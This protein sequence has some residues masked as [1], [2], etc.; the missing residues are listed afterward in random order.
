MRSST[1][2]WVSRSW[3]SCWYAA[4]TSTWPKDL[5]PTSASRVRKP[6]CKVQLTA[7]SG[8]SDHDDLSPSRR[9]RISRKP[10]RRER[11]IVSA[12]LSL[13]ACAKRS[14]LCTQGSRVRPASGVPCALLLSE[15]DEDA[16]LGQI[17]S[18]EC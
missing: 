6:S 2:N 7:T 10:P 14:F 11:R 18:R 9:P 5:V 1:R 8:T 15:G 12:A 4:R 13:L 16:K 17:L 3:A